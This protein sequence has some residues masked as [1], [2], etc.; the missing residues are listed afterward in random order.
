[1]SEKSKVFIRVNFSPTMSRVSFA[2]LLFVS[3]VGAMQW[4]EVN[5][6][7]NRSD[8]AQAIAFRNGSI[9]LFGMALFLTLFA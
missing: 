2:V 6:A 8:D 7:L 3:I 5:Q 9:F 1:M 4:K